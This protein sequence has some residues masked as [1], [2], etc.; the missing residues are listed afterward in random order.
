MGTA[1]GCM[2]PNGAVY[3]AAKSLFDR[4]STAGAPAVGVRGPKLSHRISVTSA[5]LSH[6]HPLSRS[7]SFAHSFSP[8]V[9]L[10]LFHCVSLGVSQGALTLVS[11]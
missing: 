11:S 7:S 9:C 1:A 6:T 4:Q 3:C 8:P 5:T 10:F 2:G